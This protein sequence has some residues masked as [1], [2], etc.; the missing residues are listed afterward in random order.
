MRVVI[1]STPAV[2]NIS[3]SKKNW[4][5]WSKMY[6]SIRVKYPLFLSD[7]SATWIFSTYFQNRYSNFM[8]I[9]QVGAELFHADGRTDGQKDRQYIAKLI[10]AFR[11]FAK[12]HKICLQQDQ[13]TKTASTEERF[14]GN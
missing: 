1:F 9:R 5:I 6:I 13:N 7:F 2:W 12:V 10:I 4:E 14:T 8:K 3:H 11:S